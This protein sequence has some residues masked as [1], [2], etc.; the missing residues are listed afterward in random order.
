MKDF[1]PREKLEVR[2]EKID[3]IS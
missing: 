1:V 3:L 2:Q